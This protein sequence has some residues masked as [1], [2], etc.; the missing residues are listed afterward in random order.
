MH[1][2]KSSKHTQCPADLSPKAK[3]R[4][5][6]VFWV[7]HNLPREPSSGWLCTS[8]GTPSPVLV[9][10]ALLW[11]PDDLDRDV[12]LDPRGDGAPIA[13]GALYGP[14]RGRPHCFSPGGLHVVCVHLFWCIDLV[15]VLC[16]VL[17]IGSICICVCSIFIYKVFHQFF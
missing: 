13:P 5:W 15:L 10:Q 2:A 17:S 1:S 4:S 6:E 16:T 11:I 8:P 3:P 9:L 7:L 14:A 12:I